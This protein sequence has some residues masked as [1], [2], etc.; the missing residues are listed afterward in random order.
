MEHSIGIYASKSKA[1][2]PIVCR[3]NCLMTKRVGASVEQILAENLAALM[4][5]DPKFDT[6]QKVAAATHGAINQTTVGRILRRRH[7]VTIATLS[8]LA[9]AF[10]LEPYQ[11]LI[12]GLDAK[13]P[14]VL[15]S[16][17]PAEERLYRALEEARTPDK[18]TQ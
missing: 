7:K 17:S 2:L 6:Q 3:H 16:L 11:L 18:G 14:Q 12:Y 9:R 15:R 13:N 8:A 1:P 5:V 4:R 10:D